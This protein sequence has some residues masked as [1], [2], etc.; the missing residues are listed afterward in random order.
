MMKVIRGVVPA[1]DLWEEVARKNKF[2]FPDYT[3]PKVYES[4]LQS[5]AVES[6]AASN[7]ENQSKSPSGVPLGALAESILIDLT[8][9]I[10]DR[11]SVLDLIPALPILFTYGL[12][13]EMYMDLKKAAIRI[14][15]DQG[16]EWPLLMKCI[17]LPLD[18]RIFVERTNR[19]IPKAATKLSKVLS[20]RI[21]MIRSYPEMLRYL[22]D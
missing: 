4:M 9:R 14:D 10:E 11:P 12:I 19:L 20:E 6:F 18:D 8:S 1:K 3:N 2:S 17:A 13:E 16:G 5:V 21:S 15:R 22:S 7:P